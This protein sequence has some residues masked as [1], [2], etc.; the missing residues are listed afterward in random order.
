MANVVLPPGK[1]DVNGTAIR[2]KHEIVYMV[3]ISSGTP[4]ESES[5]RY[6]SSISGQCLHV[7]LM[8]VIPRK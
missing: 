5:D 4:S 1:V 6:S 2:S 7:H 8:K 3:T